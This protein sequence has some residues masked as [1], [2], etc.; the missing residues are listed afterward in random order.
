MELKR[1]VTGPSGGI[2]TANAAE[3]LEG[4]VHELDNPPSSRASL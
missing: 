1:K 4:M 2:D 3:S